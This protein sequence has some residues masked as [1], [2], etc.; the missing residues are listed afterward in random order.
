MVLNSVVETMGDVET[1]IEA[2]TDLSV[3]STGFSVV[4]SVVASIIV[5]TGSLDRMV[6]S[7]VSTGLILEENDTVLVDCELVVCVNSTGVGV[8]SITIPFR[9]VVTTSGWSVVNISSSKIASP[10]KS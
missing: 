5:V 4:D 8:V 1:C 2:V 7:V 6:D 10:S 3:D 9:V